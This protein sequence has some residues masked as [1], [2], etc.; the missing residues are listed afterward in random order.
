MRGYRIEPEAHAELG[1]AAATLEAD[2]EGA[3]RDFL[4][5]YW[6]TL[7]LARTTPGYGTLVAVGDEPLVIRWYLLDTFSYRIFALVED[8]ELVVLAV[9]HHGQEEDYW[10]E[11]LERLERL[12][13]EEE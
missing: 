3:A 7:E 12:E 10:L 2:R 11:R 13:D 1:H 5:D 9:A 6:K 4:D 8:D